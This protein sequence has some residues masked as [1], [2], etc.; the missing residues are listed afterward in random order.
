MDALLRFQDS[1]S[2]Y[3]LTQVALVSVV[4]QRTPGRPQRA[5]PSDPTALGYP[6]QATLERIAE[7]KAQ[8]HRGSPRSHHGLDPA[9][10]YSQIW[11]IARS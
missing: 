2:G 1:L 10:R 6:W 5:N 9:G 7:Y 4:A 8:R 11:C 3:T